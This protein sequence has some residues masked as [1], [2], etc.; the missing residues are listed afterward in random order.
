M[1]LRGFGLLV[2]AVLL[3]PL[4]SSGC[5]NSGHDA[6]LERDVKALHVMRTLVLLEAEHHEKQGV[7]ATTFEQ[8]EPETAGFEYK[9]AAASAGG[10]NYALTAT[11]VGYELQG[12]PTN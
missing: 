1:R 8:L 2:W 3:A 7:F 10:Y 4:V 9:G 12:R 6:R 5:A 11:S